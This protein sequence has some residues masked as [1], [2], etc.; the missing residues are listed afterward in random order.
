MAFSSTGP[1]RSAGSSALTLCAREEGFLFSFT[2][3]D[4]LNQF[5]FSCPGDGLG[6]IWNLWNSGPKCIIYVFVIILIKH[7]TARLVW[8]Q[9]SYLVCHWSF[10]QAEIYLQ[11][12]Y[13]HLLVY[14][15]QST[16]LILTFHE[17]GIPNSKNSILI[18]QASQSQPLISGLSVDYQI[19]S[20]C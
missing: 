18:I 14:L 13:D 3:S 4:P 15:L 20:P 17:D 11:Q 1:V 6:N 10:E 2:S 16:L 8:K 12:K 19:S 5:L 9:V 7:S